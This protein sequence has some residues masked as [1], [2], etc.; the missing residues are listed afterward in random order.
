MATTTN[1]VG[2]K[3]II[4]CDDSHQ[5]ASCSPP[6]LFYTQPDD[7]EEEDETQAKRHYVT[8]ITL[9]CLSNKKKYAMV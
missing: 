5:P 2:Q 1:V 4:R 9:H 8:F 7:D 6:I 3:V